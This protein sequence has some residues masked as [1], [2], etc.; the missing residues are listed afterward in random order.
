MKSI[1]FVQYTD[2][3]IYPPL[4]RAALLLA[5]RG[6]SVKFLGVEAEGGARDI[7]MASHPLIEVKL[8]PPH[9]RGWGKAASYMNFL[10]ACRNEMRRLR[11][12]IVY[13]SDIRSFPVGLWAS[14][15]NGVTTILHEHDSPSAGASLAMKSLLRVRRRFAQRADLCVIPQDERADRFRKAT[16]AG[17]VSVAFNCPLLKE[18]RPIRPSRPGDGLRLWHHGSIGPSQL[19]SAVITALTKLPGNVRLEF[20]GYETVGTRGYIQHVLSLAN[21]LGVSGRVRFHGALRREKL[22]ELTSQADVGLTLF[23]AQFREPLVGASNKP[24]D[25]LACGLPLLTN[26]TPE[27]E[28]FFGDAGVAVSCNPESPGDIARAVSWLNDHPESRAAM[29]E[30]GQQ[31]IRSVWNY[32]AQFAKVIEVLDGTSGAAEVASSR[33]ERQRIHHNECSQG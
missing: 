16:G 23:S 18:L 28:G 13:C 14:Y 26:D 8:L 22:Y 7:K 32:E 5:D 27:W 19:P 6:W 30:K 24:F 15:Q 12:S 17:R 2:P 31:L 29:A 1:L 33:F 25:Y 3:S 10:A 4:E 21:D 20:A 11:P 9:R